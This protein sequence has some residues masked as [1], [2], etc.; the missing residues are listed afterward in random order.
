MNP[1][2]VLHIIDTLQVGGAQLALLN[3]IEGGKTRGFTYHVCCLKGVDQY[4]AAFSEAATLWHMD[5]GKYN[6]LSIFSIYRLVRQI[7]P[8]LIQTVLF[9]ANFYGALLARVAACPVI[10]HQQSG[11][12]FEAYRPS[13][14]NAWLTRRYLDFFPRMANHADVLLVSN[15][16]DGRHYREKKVKPEKTVVIPNG[17]PSQHLELSP[18]LRAEKRQKFR[19]QLGLA[20]ATVLISQ[21]GRLSAE[22]APTQMLSAFM[23]LSR[24]AADVHLCFVGEGTEK[25]NLL[26]AWQAFGSPA[27]IHILGFYDDISE[28]FAATDI[29]ALSS[30]QEAFGMVIL[31]G[32]G[33]CL[34]VV[35][36]ACVGPSDLV[37]HEQ[38]GLLVPIGDTTQFAAAVLRLVES[39]SLR[40]SLGEQGQATLKNKYTIEHIQQRFEH[41]YTQVIERKHFAR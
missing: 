34:P 31:E 24:Q 33:F 30:V 6:L 28:V 37:T 21:I 19:E 2:T 1:K 40:Q 26:S 12:G 32:W 27:N 14:P 22:K 35:A 36:S 38:D 5:Q 29:L 39:P 11:T 16:S 3:L 13:F 18:S 4:T 7:K 41:L 9:K 10:L 17:V 8:D 23:Q 25:E 20:D 15:T